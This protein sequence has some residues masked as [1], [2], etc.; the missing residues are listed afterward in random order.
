MN[1]NRLA[2]GDRDDQ[3]RRQE[4]FKVEHAWKADTDARLLMAVQFFV[5]L[6][7]ILCKKPV[8]ILKV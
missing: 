1:E 8:V 4:G 2:T 7:Q 3:K 5:S 6:R